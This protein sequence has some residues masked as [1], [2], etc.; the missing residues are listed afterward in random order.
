MLFACQPTFSSYMSRFA[1]NNTKQIVDIEE[2]DP[3]LAEHAPNKIAYYRDA[4][5]DCNVINAHSSRHR[6]R[7]KSHG[8]PSGQCYSAGSQR[9]QSDRVDELYKARGD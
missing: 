5:S 6:S 4:G 8:G 7:T 3:D 9:K 2:H 1:C